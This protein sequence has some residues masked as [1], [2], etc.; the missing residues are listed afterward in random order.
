[1]PRGTPAG[2][3][4]YRDG[5]TGPTPPDDAA[6]F[7]PA[8]VLDGQART[9]ARQRLD[10]LAPHRALGRLAELADWAAGVQ[11]RCPAAP[12]R[13]PRLLVFAGDH[14]VTAEASAYRA[15][16]A[17]AVTALLTGA[18][19]AAVLARNAGVG[20]R[21]LDLAVDADLADVPEETTRHKVRRGSGRIDR[22]PALTRDEAVRAVV[23]GRAIADE[24]I[25][26]GADVLVAAAAGT[27][28]VTPATVL[29]ALL[30]GVE[31]HTVVGRGAGLDDAGWV[32]TAA[33]VRDAARRGRPQVVDPV[34]LLAAVGGADIAA[35]AGLLGQAA[36]RRTPVLLDDLVTAAAALVADRMCFGARGWWLAGHR[37][38]EP[39]HRAAL[40]ALG[41]EP[42]LDAGVGAAGGVGALLALQ[43]LQ[44]AVAVLADSGAG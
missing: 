38:P 4:L 13:R 6:D 7:L 42:V 22:E 25:D 32:H 34:A 40:Q 10:R 3:G 19:P 39:A 33:A 41:K 5:V 27:A 24:E 11:G 23:A 1:M 30:T 2:A 28:G 26:A 35:L 20:L 31:P 29:T 17:D 44:A 37:S 36:L 21:V 15:P 16:A 8:P 9:E 18:S 43:V 14:G 12:F